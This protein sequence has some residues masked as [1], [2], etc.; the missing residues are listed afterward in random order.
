MSITYLF[1]WIF[2]LAWKCI[3]FF[4]EVL[5]QCN[6]ESHESIL[7]IEFVCF[8]VSG[9]YKDECTYIKVA[10]CGLHYEVLVSLPITMA[11]TNEGNTLISLNEQNIKILKGAIIQIQCKYIEMCINHFMYR[12]DCF[13]APIE[14][15][16]SH[17]ELVS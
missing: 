1:F 4:L 12:K 3:R 11:K 2:S 9:D 14:Y 15:M 5:Q 16:P 7:V 17:L 13:V 10:L 8:F 6:I